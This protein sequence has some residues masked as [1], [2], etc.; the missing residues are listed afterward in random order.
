MGSAVSCS[1]KTVNVQ[2]EVTL[3]ATNEV[4]SP[5]IVCGKDERV[6]VDPMTSPPYKWICSL[7]THFS[8]EGLT[9]RAS[10]FKIY[11]P[12]VGR[13]AIV[14][15]GHVTYSHEGGGYPDRITVTFP[16]ETPI[17]V[18]DQKNM[19]AP[20][21]HIS[22]KNPDYDYGLILL[23]GAGNS[24]DGFGWSA[25][26]PDGELNNLLVTNCGYP[27]DKEVGTMW[28]TG[29]KITSV[30]AKQITYMNDTFGGQ[31]GSPVYT[32]YGGYW[33]VIGVHLGAT[34]NPPEC[35]NIATRFTIPVS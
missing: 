8:K 25:I 7:S 4:S 28:I 6:Q 30:K 32:W 27:S 26:L 19:Y 5:E 11:L 13:T 22:S 21:E 15:S 34:G 24:N 29:G 12:D 17:A 3:P 31:S 2:R 10:G 20:P 33:T 16:G 35:P 9:G 1:S 14:T 18:R 23:P